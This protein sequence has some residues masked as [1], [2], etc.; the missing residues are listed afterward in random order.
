MIH[1]QMCNLKLKVKNFLGKIEMPW[2][3]DYSFTLM[4]SQIV[5][6]WKVAFFDTFID[7]LTLEL[8]LLNLKWLI[9]S[10]YKPPSQNEQL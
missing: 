1:F 8:M 2:E 10:A 9:L 5:D 3:E 4:K 7:I 6:L